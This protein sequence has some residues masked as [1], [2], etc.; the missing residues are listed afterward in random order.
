MK[1]TLIMLVLILG[2]CLFLSACSTSTEPANSSTSAIST[3]D[4]AALQQG[5]TLL[6]ERCASCHSVEKTTRRTGTAAE[7]DKIVSEM[8]QRGANLTEDEKTIL[9]QYL[10]VTYK[11]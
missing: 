6:E 10:A 2:V 5:K 1:K 4:E 3:P 9:V 8:I 7:W 11:P